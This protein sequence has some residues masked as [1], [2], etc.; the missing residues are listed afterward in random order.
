MKNMDTLNITESLVTL[1]LA[2]PIE[3]K[4]GL[5]KQRVN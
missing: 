2:G 5:D 4:K 1:I 3:R